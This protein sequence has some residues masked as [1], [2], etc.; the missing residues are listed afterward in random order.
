[1][2]SLETIYATL[3]SPQLPDMIERIAYN[4]L[5]A[6]VRPSISIPDANC[7]FYV[8]NTPDWWGHQYLQAINQ[9]AA[10]DLGST[11]PWPGPDNG[12]SQVYGLEPN[13]PCC[14]TNHQQG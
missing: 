14:T 5:P 12:Y 7:P 1:M 9:I 11:V 4:A 10:K 6:Q 2:Y 8:Q 13:Y 3:G